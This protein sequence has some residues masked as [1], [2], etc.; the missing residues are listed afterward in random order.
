MSLNAYCTGDPSVEFFAF[1][2]KYSFSSL[3]LYLSILYFNDNENL[4][5]FVL[6]FSK[7]WGRNVEKKSTMKK[8][9]NVLQ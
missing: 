3:Y 2:E 8:L 1:I 7:K 9:P 6:S 4:S 5:S